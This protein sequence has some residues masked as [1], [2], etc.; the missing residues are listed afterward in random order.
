VKGKNSVVR[1]PLRGNPAGN[2][3][4][5]I[6]FSSQNPSGPL[7]GVFTVQV[8]PVPPFSGGGLSASDKDHRQ[9]KSSSALGGGPMGATLFPRARPRSP[10]SPRARA[11]A[12]SGP[13]PP[14]SLP[15]GPRRQD[16]DRRRPTPGPL[17]PAPSTDASR[18]RSRV[19]LWG[20]YEAPTPPLNSSSSVE[21]AAPG[22]HKSKTR[23]LPR[24][25][26][27]INNHTARRWLFAPKIAPWPSPDP[28]GS[29]AP[30]GFARVA[31]PPSRRRADQ[32]QNRPCFPDAHGAPSGL[33]GRPRGTPRGCPA[34]GPKAGA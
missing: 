21:P 12:S 24:Q 10:V 19:P 4:T 16:K 27:G 22:A 13:R 26:P 29:R 23:A 20:R 33:P 7:A 6:C 34:G 30:V 2:S 3:F 11:G 17:R 8:R 25:D 5:L 14:G 32:P 18:R 9:A 31:S 15:R 1:S 28:P